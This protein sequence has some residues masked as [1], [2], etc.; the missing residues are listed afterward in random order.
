MNAKTGLITELQCEGT[1][2]Q[3]TKEAR[4]RLGRDKGF[5]VRFNLTL[6]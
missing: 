4:Y 3:S 2:C 1:C 6:L 5:E